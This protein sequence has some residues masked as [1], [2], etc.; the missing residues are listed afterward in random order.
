MNG[1]VDIAVGAVPAKK[2][3]AGRTGGAELD[4][5]HGFASGEGARGLGVSG[6]RAG[7]FSPS[8]T[9]GAWL[10]ETGDPNVACSVLWHEL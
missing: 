4:R 5:V 6:G 10:V 8:V 1:V 3:L 9:V 2:V 7:A